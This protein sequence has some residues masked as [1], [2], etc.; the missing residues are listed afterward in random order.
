MIKKKRN[1]LMIFNEVVF[2]FQSWQSLRKE[3]GRSI[4]SLLG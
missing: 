3:K 1:C 4:I 2:V